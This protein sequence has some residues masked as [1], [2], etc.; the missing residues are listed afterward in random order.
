MKR[1]IHFDTLKLI[2]VFIVFAL[3][4][5]GAYHPEYAVYWHKLPTALLLEGVSGKNAVSALAVFSGYFA[6]KSKQKSILFYSSRRYFEFFFAA[7]FINSLWGLCSIHGW[8]GISSQTIQNSNNVVLTI[9]YESVCIRGTIYPALWFMIPFL[10]G[11]IISYTNGKEESS[12]VEIIIQIWCFYIV[13]QVWIS[14]CLL[15]SLVA[16][17]QKNK[18]VS[19]FYKNTIVQLIIII[20]FFVIK[21]KESNLTYLID[22]ICVSQVIL[23]ID[24]NER[25]KRLLSFK[26]GIGKNVMSIFLLHAIVY[27]VVSPFLFNLMTNIKYN[28]AFLCVL[29]IT[30]FIIILLS[31]PTTYLLNI[32]MKMFTTGINKCAEI[33]KHINIR[34]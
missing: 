8:G 17:L 26:W 2:A 10:I 14:I 7:F 9:L 16:C 15:G 12:P 30:W 19:R 28:F 1:E 5:I 23:I 29:F 22:G 11:S 24:N 4:F 21:R 33:K 34:K 18:Y 27:R 6:Y 25:L 32:A 20:I 31:Y 3:H 13:N